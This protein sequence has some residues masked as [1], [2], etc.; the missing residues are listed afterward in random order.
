MTFNTR[1]RRL[2]NFIPKLFISGQL[3]EHVSTFNFLGL[4]LD[5]HLTWNEHINKISNKISREIGVLNKLKNYLPLS[6]MKLI[7]NSLIQS[8]LNYC[9]LIWG[10]NN[11]RVYKLQ[12]KAIRTITRSKYNSHTEPLFKKLSILKLPDLLL[13]NSLKFYFKYLNAKLPIYFL[14]YDIVHRYQSHDHNTRNCRQF[15]VGTARLEITKRCIRYH[16]PNVLN[17]F[18]ELVLIKATTHSYNGFVHYARNH[19]IN[20]YIMN[21]QINNC[22]ICNRA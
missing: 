20:C 22:Y 21:C 6:I 19:I 15:T 9:N 18:P 16:I 4:I 17:S 12:K 7:Y 11:N 13:L 1:Q 8:H 14:Q 3:I 2:N 5:Q 10:F